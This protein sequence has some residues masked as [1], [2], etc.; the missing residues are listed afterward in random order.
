[1]FGGLCRTAYGAKAFKRVAGDQRLRDWLLKW[2]S[3][4]WEELT[5]PENERDIH[6]A[7]TEFLAF[8]RFHFEGTSSPRALKPLTRSMAADFGSL[9]R[10]TAYGNVL[11]DVLAAREEVLGGQEALPLDGAVAWLKEK[12]EGAEKHG[13]AMV[14]VT[15]RFRVPQKAEELHIGSSWQPAPTYLAALGKVSVESRTAPGIRRPV[16]GPSERRIQLSAE[17]GGEMTTID[18]FRSDSE[19]V[20]AL[21]HWA[22]RL[23][24]RCSGGASSNRDYFY[25]EGFAAAVWLVLAGVWPHDSGEALLEPMH[26]AALGGKPAGQPYGQAP[27]IIMRIE[28]LDTPPEAV[29]DAYRNLQ[30]AAGFG[31][32][33]R[34]MSVEN[35]ALCL[36]ALDAMAIAAVHPGDAGFYSEVLRRYELR[37][38]DQGAAVGA[39]PHT[40][41]GRDKARKALQR[42]GLWY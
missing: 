8:C 38:A 14:D 27:R 17:T 18:L 7:A 33:G 24:S 11:I 6:Y 5:D 37:A 13:L 16:D 41:A 28:S 36:A 23:A 40:A 2:L 15:Y 31:R 22:D 21:I 4:E 29:S 39:F 10:V 19:Q 25:A 42:A 1:M 26:A 32:R 20:H 12:T 35:E 3:E 30:K 34:K 9:T